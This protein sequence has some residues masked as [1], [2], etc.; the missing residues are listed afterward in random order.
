MLC[1]DISELK[2]RAQA[3]LLQQYQGDNVRGHSRNRPKG[4]RNSPQRQTSTRFADHFS[5]FILNKSLEASPKNITW[6]ILY[7]TA[8]N[9]LCQICLKP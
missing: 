9:A 6:C 7:E 4:G 3:I 5:Q 1:N 8:P 2:D